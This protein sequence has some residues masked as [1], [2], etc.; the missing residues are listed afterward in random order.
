[1]V[2][3]YKIVETKSSKHSRYWIFVIVNSMYRFKNDKFQKSRGGNSRVLDV[4]CKSCKEHIAYYQKDGPGLLKRVYVDRFIDINPNT[5]GL[6]GNP[7]NGFLGGWLDI[8]KE[9]E[10]GVDFYVAAFRKKMVRVRVVTKIR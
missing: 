9:K 4:C 1:M 8:K 10:P 6:D 2:S 3:Q 7:V 5:P